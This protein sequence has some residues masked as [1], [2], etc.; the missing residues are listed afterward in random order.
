VKRRGVL[1]TL[2][3]NEGCGKSTQLK[4]LFAALKKKGL[5]VF[6]T[7]DPGGT[8]ISDGIRAVLLDHKNKAMTPLCET[9]LYMA[10]RAQ[11]VGQVITPKLEAGTVVLC[12]RWVD[13]TV[14]YQGYAG[15]VSVDWIRTIG[16]EATRGVVPAISLFLDLPL[17]TGLRRAKKRKAADRIEAK[18]L[19]FHRKVRRGYDAIAKFEPRRFKRIRIAESDSAQMIHAKILKAL[20][21]VL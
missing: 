18:A 3:G 21:H 1:I 9:L 7:R 19:S 17:E 6:L 15:G 2:D 11:L 13:A 5:N 10:S 12:D 14:A 16:R 4:L 20:E 8:R